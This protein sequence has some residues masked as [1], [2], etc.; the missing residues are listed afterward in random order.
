VEVEQLSTREAAPD[1]AAIININPR[2]PIGSINF[3]LVW[4]D[5]G[6]AHRTTG[7]AIVK[8]FRPVAVAKK[9]LTNGEAF[10][11][12]NTSFEEREITRFTQTG[13]HTNWEE[14]RGKVARGYIRPDSLIGIQ[15]SEKPV[16]ILQGQ[17]VDLRHV[18]SQM[19]ISARMKALENGRFGNWIRVENPTSKKVV[20]ARVTAP[21]Q[22]E[23]R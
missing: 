14:L 5:K 18:S 11:E 7:N 20:R 13:F 6:V 12:E 8:V 15:N 2:M 23:L 17:M 16:E 4:E 3:E 1:S 19:T 21:G 10:T 22:V 9:I